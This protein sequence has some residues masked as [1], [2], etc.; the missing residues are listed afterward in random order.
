[1]H[2]LLEASRHCGFSVC[3]L[4]SLVPAMMFYFKN[5]FTYLGT[6]KSILGE[7]EPVFAINLHDASIPLPP[8]LQRAN[9]TDPIK[10]DTRSLKEIEDTLHHPIARNIPLDIYISKIGKLH[11]GE[12]WDFLYKRVHT[13]VGFV[14]NK[15]ANVNAVNPAA[16]FVSSR[17]ERVA[18]KSVKGE[19][20]KSARRVSARHLSARTSNKT[21]SKKSKNANKTSRSKGVRSVRTA[22]KNRV[23]LRPMGSVPNPVKVQFNV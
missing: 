15:N 18:E 5:G 21:A 11:E 2:H 10:V 12:P 17:A 6:S 7:V 1:M 4:K 14:S 3:I 13:R 20:S 23:V 9:S 8:H 19:K 22:S 16:P